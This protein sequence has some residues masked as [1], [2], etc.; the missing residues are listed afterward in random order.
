ML[1][2][3]FQSH[4]L[5]TA[6]LPKGRAAPLINTLVHERGINRVNVTYARGV[7]RLTPLRHRGVGESTEKEIVNVIVSV[8]EAD[9]LFEFIFFAADI[10]RPHGGLMYQ[11][12]LTSATLFNLPDEPEEE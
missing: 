7:G 3:E 10:N 8:E 2:S 5:I 4:K 11:Q 12:P 1:R 6:I 9:E